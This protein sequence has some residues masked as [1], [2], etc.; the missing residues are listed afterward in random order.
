MAIDLACARKKVARGH[1]NPTLRR[2]FPTYALLT[3]AV[4]ALWLGGEASP[5]LRRLLWI[6]PFTAA[7]TAGLVT[8]VLRPLALVWIGAFGV[9]A[10]QLGGTG[11]A[12]ARRTAALLVIFVLGVGLMAHQLPGF[13]NPMVIAPTRFSPDAIPYRLHLNFDKTLIGVLFLGFCHARMVRGAEWRTMLASAAPIT[14]G[15]IFLVMMLSLGIGY[16]RFDPKFPP[17][18]W[19]WLVV[20]LCFTCVAEEAFFR[21]FLQAGLQRLWAR[22]PHGAWLALGT[23]AFLFGL[24]H[25]GGGPIYVALATV[26]GAG[27][28]WTYLRTGRIE[29]SILTHFALNTAHFFWFTYPAL[30]PGG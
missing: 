8:G 29:A 26:A 3:T 22:V 2:L 30:Q 14:L 16:V 28:G 19:L 23:A 7:V 12:P 27:Y 17:E 20:N 25:A 10:S 4:L 11:V 1:V 5:A 24:A 21:A 18:T 9:A 13:N 15:T 6:A